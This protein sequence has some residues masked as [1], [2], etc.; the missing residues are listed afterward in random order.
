MDPVHFAMIGIV[1]RMLGLARPP[2]RLCLMSSC[3]VA[4]IRIAD[5]IKDTTIM[6]LPMLEVLAQVI[7]WPDVALFPPHRISSESLR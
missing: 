5:A 2:Y 4:G 7:V 6:L 3:A 1:S